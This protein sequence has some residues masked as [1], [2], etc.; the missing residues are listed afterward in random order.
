[1]NATQSCSSGSGSANS[2]PATERNSRIGSLFHWN[3]K[4]LETIS[5]LAKMTNLSSG[6]QE[7]IASVIK[8]V[9]ASKTLDCDTDNNND[10]SSIRLIGNSGGGSGLGESDQIHHVIVRKKEASIN[11]NNNNVDDAIVYDDESDGCIS[12]VISRDVVPGTSGGVVDEV[13]FGDLRIAAAVKEEPLGKSYGELQEE[14]CWRADV[15]LD[16]GED[17]E[18]DEECAQ[19][20][21]MARYNV[22]YLYYILSCI[23]SFYN[24]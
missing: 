3:D 16:Y 6:E 1:M 7:V 19:D 9:V 2:L 13:R 5:K 20:L 10:G 11:N 18:E 23:K 17:E 15:S 12:R 4:A 14:S 22:H 8:S 24:L 21:S